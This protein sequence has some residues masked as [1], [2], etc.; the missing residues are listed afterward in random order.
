M[1]HNNNYDFGSEIRHYNLTAVSPEETNNYFEAL[2]HVNVTNLRQSIL[3]VEKIQK[4]ISKKMSFIYVTGHRTDDITHFA[5]I[6][7]S[8]INADLINMDEIGLNE[9]FEKEEHKKHRFI[10]KPKNVSE[11]AYYN[12]SYNLENIIKKVKSKRKSVILIS[13]D[14]HPIN[15]AIIQN[16][17]GNRYFKN[18]INFFCCDASE[19][20]SKKR[21]MND[22]EKEK[23]PLSIPFIKQYSDRYILASSIASSNLLGVSANESYVIDKV[24]IDQLQ[25]TINKEL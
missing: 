21:L 24:L 16:T 6:V 2:P 11:E 3:G 8:Y 10:P 17:L 25:K 18:V 23:L 4:A 14:L 19:E 15:T 1:K 7:A 13:S 22:I 9:Y 5:N 12:I 20:I